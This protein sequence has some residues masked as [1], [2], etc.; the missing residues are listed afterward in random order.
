MK[1]SIPP[2]IPSRTSGL[3][4]F[5]AALSLA[6]AIEAFAPSEALAANECGIA[7]GLP[8]TAT[9]TSAGNP[10]ATGITYSAGSSGLNLNLQSVGVNSAAGGVVVSAAGP[11]PVGPINIGATG[12][13]T[14]NTTGVANNYGIGILSDPR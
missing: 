9:C 1:R 8:P 3:A 11:F 4:L 2:F 5:S 6:K 10:Y 12:A 7:S 14:I 13:N